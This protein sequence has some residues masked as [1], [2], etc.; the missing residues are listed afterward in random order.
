LTYY[1]MGELYQSLDY[2]KKA[3]EIDN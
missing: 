2:A 3:N 1:E